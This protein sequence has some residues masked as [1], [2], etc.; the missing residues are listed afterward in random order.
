M[1]S[2]GVMW[3]NDPNLPS[4][5]KPKE[6]MINTGAPAYALGHLG[7]GGRLNGPVDNPKSACMS[8]HGTAQNE[9]SAPMTP[10]SNAGCTAAQSNVWFRNLAGNVAF[11]D[12]KNGTCDVVP[13]AVLVPLDYSLQQS[14]ALSNY[15]KETTAGEPLY[16][17]PCQ[18]AAPH[19]KSNAKPNSEIESL[20]V[21]R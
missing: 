13:S 18:P 15:E 7:L 3:G 11:G 9:A 10:P 21:E 20:P 12:L 1:V 8:C 17:N 6:S 5:S 16:M 2:V 19:L 4:G 14:V